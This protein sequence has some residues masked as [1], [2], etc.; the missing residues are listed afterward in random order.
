[1]RE[2]ADEVGATF[3]VDMAHFAG[4]V[5]GKVLVGDYDPCR[6]RTSSPPRPT[7]PCAVLGADSCCVDRDLAEYVD[8][9]CPMVL[10]RSASARDGGQGRG[11][12]RSIASRPSARTPRLWSTTPACWPNGSVAGGVPVVT[13][14]TDNHLVLVDV[15]PFG[16]NGRQAESACRAAGITLNRNVVPDETNGAW[17]TSGLRLGTPAVTTL[18]MGADEMREIAD[19]LA[20]VLHGA[21]AGVIASGPNRGKPSLVQ[22]VLDDEIVQAA[23][24]RIDDLLLR[25]PLY[26]E[27]EL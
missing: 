15:R 6:T 22:F 9:G 1:M 13:G 7:R 27:I 12:G 17:Y 4:L 19:V 24:S 21:S 14:G 8:R 16:L 20:A 10:G 25:H 5:A 18:G 26:P 23:A 11:L 2:I 3:M